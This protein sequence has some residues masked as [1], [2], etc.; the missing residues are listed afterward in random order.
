MFPSRES[1]L[2]GLVMAEADKWLAS[3]REGIATRL[4]HGGPY[5][6][7]T[8][9]VDYSEGANSRLSWLHTGLIIIILRYIPY[10]VLYQ[11]CRFRLSI[12]VSLF[13][14]LWYNEVYC[15]TVVMLIV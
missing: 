15:R 4:W 11:V 6:L 14:T 10:R 5:Q 2:V 13:C 3:G 1:C 8:P 9:G 7:V 12:G